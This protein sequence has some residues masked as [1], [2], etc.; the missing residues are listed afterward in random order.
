[1]VASGASVDPWFTVVLPLGIA[2]IGAG[3]TIAV[4]AMQLRARKKE[5]E[6]D[7]AARTAREERD[8]A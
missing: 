7:L 6:I 2:L 1:M 8:R 3:A 4:M 5:L